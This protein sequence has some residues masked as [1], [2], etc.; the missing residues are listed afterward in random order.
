MTVIQI[1]ALILAIT[2]LVFLIISLSG[3]FRFPNFFT[4]LHATGVGDI[5]GS[6]L[7]ITSLIL[8]NGAN[9]LTIKILLV[10]CFIAF[11][12]PF[13]TNMIMIAA[14]HKKNYLDYNETE[15]LVKDEEE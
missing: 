12:N 3:L 11:T 4:R 7:F 1:I 5:L 6:L 9:L 13:G 10:F 2:G 8:L 14:A 15:V